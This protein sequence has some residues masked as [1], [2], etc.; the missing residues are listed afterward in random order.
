MAAAKAA[1]KAA[2]K[3]AAMPP[4]PAEMEALAVRRKHLL[5]MHLG[6]RVFWGWRALL[7]FECLV[8]W[9]PCEC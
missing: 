8:T 6:F 3:A 2:P 5:A 7:F 1:P 9:L 4:S